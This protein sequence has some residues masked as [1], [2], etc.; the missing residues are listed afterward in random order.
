MADRQSQNLNTLIQVIKE[1]YGDKVAAQFVAL[2]EEVKFEGDHGPAI[3]ASD[4]TRFL[5]KLAPVKEDT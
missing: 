1:T 4:A 5:D 3:Y 2:A